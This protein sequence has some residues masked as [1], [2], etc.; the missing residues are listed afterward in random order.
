MAAPTR[1]Y[2][3]PAYGVLQRMT[4]ANEADAALGSAF[5]SQTTFARETMMTGVTIKDFNV[6]VLSG[7]TCTGAGAWT[8]KIGKSAAGTGAISAIGTASATT[9]ADDTVI[10]GSVTE[11]NLDAGD[12][13]VFYHDAG[14][15][16][17]DNAL[18]CKAVVSYTEH[19]VS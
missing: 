15:A 3:D 2:D 16:L 6:V 10:D 11:T 5:A 8:L 19:Y 9:H 12:D 1:F 13:L 7:C 17:G 18:A 14:T 4:L